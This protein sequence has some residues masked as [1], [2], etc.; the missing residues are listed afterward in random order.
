MVFEKVAQ[1]IAEY[2]EMDASEITMESSFEELGL[3]SLDMVELIMK[4]EESLDIQ[5]EMDESL[6]TVG[7]VVGAIEAKA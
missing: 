1:E 5:L 6:K 3:D 7:D 4:L 2:K